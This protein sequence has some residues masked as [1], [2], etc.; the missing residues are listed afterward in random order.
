MYTLRTEP[1]LLFKLI[2]GNANVALI[3]EEDKQHDHI[4]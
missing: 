2:S 1:K 4:K 3:R